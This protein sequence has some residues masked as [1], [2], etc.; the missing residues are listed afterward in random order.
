MGISITIGPGYANKCYISVEYFIEHYTKAQHM[1]PAEQSWGTTS[2]PYSS[3]AGYGSSAS[4]AQPSSA[5]NGRGYNTSAPA[6]GKL[7]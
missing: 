7:P 5:Y 4:Y 6:Y 2:D 1:V 3:S